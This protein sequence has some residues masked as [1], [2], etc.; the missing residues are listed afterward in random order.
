MSFYQEWS[1]VKTQE[2]EIRTSWDS[3]YLKLPNIQWVRYHIV[4]FC[5]IVYV[6]SLHRMGSK[7]KYILS[8]T[9]SVTR[10]T[11]QSPLGSRRDP[12]EITVTPIVLRTSEKG[13]RT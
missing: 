3:I 1:V 11:E 8:V 5:I 6:V 9:I 13:T 2:P 7:R 10:K 4:V 12:V